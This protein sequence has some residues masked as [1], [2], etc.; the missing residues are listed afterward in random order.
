MLRRFSSLKVYAQN[1]TGDDGGDHG[2]GDLCSPDF[3]TKM[4]G[5]YARFCANQI[6]TPM[7]DGTKRYPD[8]FK[9]GNVSEQAEM[10]PMPTYSG[11]TEGAC[12]QCLK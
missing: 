4:S 1:R 9:A 7:K 8:S 12:C 10:C 3:W 6:H 11:A 2:A 5:G